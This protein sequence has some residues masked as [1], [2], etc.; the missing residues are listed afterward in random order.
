MKRISFLCVCAAA[1]LVAPPPTIE[2][3]DLIPLVSDVNSLPDTV[4]RTEWDIFL[5]A[6]I[7]VESEGNPNAVGKANDVGILQITPIYV[8]EVNRILKEER[9]TLSD[10]TDPNKSLEMFDIMQG[11]WN[12]SHDIDQAIHLHNPKAGPWYKERIV[13]RMNQIREEI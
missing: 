9:Y 1:L 3:G 12:P 7:M 11:Y 13:N 5:Q 6:L 10:R 8:K 4:T 2:N